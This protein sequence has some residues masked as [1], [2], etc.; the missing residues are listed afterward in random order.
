MNG[1]KAFKEIPDCQIEVSAY[2]TVKANPLT[3]LEQ[4]LRI[5]LQRLYPNGQGRNYIKTPQTPTFND[6][7]VKL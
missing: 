5:F 1:H 4:N 3:M 7:H 2:T 6:K